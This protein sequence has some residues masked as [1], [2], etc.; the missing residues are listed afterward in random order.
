L[1][2][3]LNALFEYFAKHNTIPEFN[4]NEN[5]GKLLEISKEVYEVLKSKYNVYNENNEKINE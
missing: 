2:V 5:A 1:H 4:N 3:S